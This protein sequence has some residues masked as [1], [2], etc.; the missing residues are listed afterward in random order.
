MLQQLLKVIL[1]KPAQDL[2]QLMV[3]MDRCVDPRGTGPGRQ[4]PKYEVEGTLIIIMIY[5][6]VRQQIKYNGTQLK[7][8]YK[9]YGRQTI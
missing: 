1:G 4:S 7:H 9:I 6:A 2:A 3:T 8:R 5:Y